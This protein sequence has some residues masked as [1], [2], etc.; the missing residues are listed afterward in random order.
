[1]RAA[2]LTQVETEYCKN[3]HWIYG[4]SFL[5]IHGHEIKAGASLAFLEF[6]YLPQKTTHGFTKWMILIKAGAYGIKHGRFSMGLIK[7]RSRKGL[8]SLFLA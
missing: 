4:K 3:K 2:A 1:M 7:G 6:I 5:V 8:L